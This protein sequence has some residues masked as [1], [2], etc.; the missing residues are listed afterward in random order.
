MADAAGY[1]DGLNEKLLAAIAPDA[2][3]VLEFGC[4]KGRLGAACKR[5]RAG[6]RWTGVDRSAEALTEAETR[7]D[8]VVAMDLDAPDPAHL[9]SD[10]DVT[11]L[12]DVLEHLRNPA[13]C[14][15]FAHAVLQ[16]V[17]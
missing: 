10:Y 16:L 3:S 8:A 6:L 4:A 15:R 7:L 1:F 12:G 17:L 5:A 14:L 9:A 11:V 13:D 2:R